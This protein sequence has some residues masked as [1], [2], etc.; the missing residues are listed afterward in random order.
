MTSDS[1]SLVKKL[2]FPRYVGTE[3]ELKAQNILEN[4]FETKFPGK[5]HKDEFECSD[6]YMNHILRYFYNPICGLLIILVIIGT[7]FQIYL[8]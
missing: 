4:E 7:L 5:L 3:G 8:F 2:S 1:T 6:F